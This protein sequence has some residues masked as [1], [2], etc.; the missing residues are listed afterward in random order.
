MS[1]LNAD[2]LALLSVTDKTGIV[3]FAQGL[4]DLGFTILSTGGTASA[5]RV[6]GVKVTDVAE[7]TGSPEILTFSIKLSYSFFI[8]AKAAPGALHRK[9]MAPPQ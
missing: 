7:Y 6:A 3:L 5:L 9:Y 8:A 1:Q 4:I 2:P